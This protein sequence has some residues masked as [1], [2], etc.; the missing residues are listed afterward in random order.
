MNRSA[1]RLTR[2][3]QEGKRSAQRVNV[4]NLISFNQSLNRCSV[5]IPVSQSSKAVPSRVPGYSRIEKKASQTR[6]VLNCP[7]P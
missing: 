1:N 6:S 3:Y 4:Q 5:N 2:M 7:K